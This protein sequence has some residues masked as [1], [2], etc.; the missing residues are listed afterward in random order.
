MTN[1]VE[2][3]SEKSKQ[4]W[5]LLYKKL[6]GKKWSPNVA[7]DRGVSCEVNIEPIE[8]IKEFLESNRDITR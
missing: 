5:A 1:F 7:D 8:E 6:T 4:N 2:S 3:L